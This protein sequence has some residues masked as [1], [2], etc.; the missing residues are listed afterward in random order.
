MLILQPPE[1][2]KYFL[3]QKQTN[4][5]SIRNGKAATP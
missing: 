3:Q 4:Q 2:E 1:K 5:D